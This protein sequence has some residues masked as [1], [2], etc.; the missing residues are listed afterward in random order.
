MTLP[1]NK[2]PNMRR[3]VSRARDKAFPHCTCGASRLVHRMTTPAI[4]KWWLE[5]EPE[6]AVTAMLSVFE[7]LW[8][9]RMK[10]RKAGGFL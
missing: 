1:C 9:L 2:L 8:K 6:Q 10:A 5:N 7:S 3:R 4:A